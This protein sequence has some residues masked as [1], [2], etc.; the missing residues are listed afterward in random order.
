MILLN[1]YC[2]LS[3]LMDLISVL[4]YIFHKPGICPALVTCCQ[5]KVECGGCYLCLDLVVEKCSILW[6]R[7]WEI[8]LMCRKKQKLS[9]WMQDHCTKKMVTDLSFCSVSNRRLCLYHQLHYIYIIFTF[10]TSSLSTPL[11]KQTARTRTYRK[12]WK[13][14]NNTTAGLS[15]WTKCVG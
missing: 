2:A 14:W 9:L 1:A 7:V 11:S 5:R 3:P 10:C 15:D 12:R 13:Y 4:R 8:E 6:P